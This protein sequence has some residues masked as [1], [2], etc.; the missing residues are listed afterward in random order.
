MGAYDEYEFLISPVLSPVKLSDVDDNLL[1]VSTKDFELNNENLA[2]A[3][4]SIRK[5][6]AF[7][8]L[9]NLYL[10]STNPAKNINLKG[11]FIL[12]TSSAVKRK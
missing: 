10:G 12:T 5:S 6:K 1:S 4:L 3:T 8:S 9:T 7:G 2:D 11:D